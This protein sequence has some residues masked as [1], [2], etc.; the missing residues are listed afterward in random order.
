MSRKVFT[1]GFEM[2]K[3]S[4]WNMTE[5]RGLGLISRNEQSINIILFLSDSCFILGLKLA[6][7]K[8]GRKVLYA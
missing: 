1:M 4:V 8:M 3:G 7:T 5:S 6:L 2:E